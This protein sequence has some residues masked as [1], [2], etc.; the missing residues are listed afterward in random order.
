MYFLQLWKTEAYDSI[1]TQQTEKWLLWNANDSIWKHFLM[2]WKQCKVVITCR[3]WW[4]SLGSWNEELHLSCGYDNSSFY[5]MDWF[6]QLS[7]KF[8]TLTMYS[9]ML[10]N[11]KMLIVVFQILEFV[12]KGAGPSVL[13]GMILQTSSS[14]ANPDI[15][16]DFF[17]FLKSFYW[18]RFFISRLAHNAQEVM[19][20]PEQD[21]QPEWP[22]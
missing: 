20:E 12:E 13:P 15:N 4:P 11:S 2:D 9:L 7:S 16:V 17:F 5:L 14:W 8:W 10:V 22:D 1:S 19:G 21:S 3:C 18:R 6:C